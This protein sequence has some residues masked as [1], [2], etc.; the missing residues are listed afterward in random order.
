MNE[1]FI[2]KNFSSGVW[3]VSDFISKTLVSP[4]GLIKMK[5]NIYPNGFNQRFESYVSVMATLLSARIHCYESTIKL[6]ILTP[7][8]IQRKER[9]CNIYW[10][11][12]TFISGIEQYVSHQTCQNFNETLLNDGK[13]TIFTEVLCSSLL[14][15]QSESLTNLSLVNS[16][17]IRVDWTVCNLSSFPDV[18][19]SRICHGLIPSNSKLVPFNFELAPRGIRNSKKGFISLHLCI[20]DVYKLVKPLPVNITFTIKNYGADDEVS[21]DSLT[22]LFESSESPCWGSPNFVLFEKAIKKSCLTIELRSIYN[23]Y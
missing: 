5:I 1:K 14:E 10:P 7:R 8:N 16:V 20:L 12:Y 21:Y 23:T 22:A 18:P 17:E 4:D 3:K 19:N 9:D 15:R 13:L 6:S 2:V 11:E